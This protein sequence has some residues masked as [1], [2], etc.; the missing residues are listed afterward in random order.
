[1]NDVPQVPE[2]DDRP[3]DAERESGRTATAEFRI[4]VP[5]PAKNASLTR[6]DIRRP[7][8]PAED[9]AEDEG[10]LDEDP[11]A[12]AESEDTGT[13]AETA[14]EESTDAQEEESETDSTEEI[15]ETNEDASAGDEES[16]DAND[17]PD[18]PSPAPAP[19]DD[20][21]DEPD[22]EPDDLEH[23]E[24]E[25]DELEHDEPEPEPDDEPEDEHPAAAEEDAQPE[26]EPLPEARPEA[27]PEPPAGDS[28]AE[29]TRVE[30]LPST[31]RTSAPEPST[32]EQPPAQRAPEQPAAPSAPERSAAESPAAWHGS[33]PAAAQHAPAPPTAPQEAVGE[34]VW[35]NS[36]RQSSPPA[37]WETPRQAPVGEFRPESVRW[38]AGQGAAPPAA[39][40]QSG[41]WEVAAPQPP[42]GQG[43]RQSGPWEVAAPQAQ[44]PYA[45]APQPPGPVEPMGEEV[46]RPKR[47]RLTIVLVAALVLVV[48]VVAGQLI[49]PVPDPTVKLTLASS[50]LFQGAAPALPWPSA[51]Q[52]AV[53][54]DGLGTMGASGGSAPTPTASVAK[55]M[56]AFV[57][58]RDHPLKTGQAGPVLAVSP[59]GV[60][61]IPARKKRGESLLGITAGQRLTERKALE[62]LLII[63]ANDLAH[64]LA[65]WDSGGDQPFVAKMNAAA[66][67]LGMTGTRYTDPS[68]YDSGTVSTAAD[69]VKLLRA[70]MQVP[71]FTEIVN[72]RA[73][74]PDDGSPARPGGNVLVGQYGVVGGK[75]GYTDA[76]GGNF[77]FAA[78]KR[79]GGVPTLILGA[80]MGQKSPSAQGAVQAAAQLIQAAENAMTAATLAPKGGGVGKVDDGLGGTTP[81]RAGAPVTVV[82][83]PGLRVPVGV[84]ADPPHRG[85]AGQR[86]GQVTAGAAKVPLVLGSALDEPSYLKRLIRLN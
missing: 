85:D 73:Y 74:V 13:D 63:S 76:A 71:A 44:A 70:A 53:Y 48:G 15:A 17:E 37:G 30:R 69:Q 20:A 66:R 77:V 6:P 10:V 5:A 65:R 11:P 7:A 47:R 67:E 28:P 50:H 60:A 59:Q 49:R 41:P 26:A 33:E 57:Y 62:A 83:W 68:G 51:G 35:W 24:P 9:P 54:V 42:A 12:E 80:V 45:H 27:R 14:A 8:K 34:E 61:E 46:R 72:R 52:S 58:L 1:M 84:R 55:V 25:H 4:P 18:D 79:V 29:V 32:P 39:P 43:Q 36:P 31:W 3:E 23:A 2:P 21:E 82:G 19:P 38:D 40:R 56:T 86:V 22:T 16:E 78:R 75:T 64:E 81:L